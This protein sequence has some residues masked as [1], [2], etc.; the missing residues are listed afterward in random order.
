M[1]KHHGI[2]HRV[3][4]FKDGL[5]LF[6]GSVINDDNMGESALFQFPYIGRK[7]FIRLKRRDQDNRLFSRVICHLSSSSLHKPIYTHYRIIP[8]IV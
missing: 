7:P 5:V 3:H 2:F 6:A 4:F 8:R 1:V